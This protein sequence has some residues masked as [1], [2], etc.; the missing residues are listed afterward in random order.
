MTLAG[1][2]AADEV[3]VG[4]STILRA[5][6][7]AITPDR[8]RAFV[9]AVSLAGFDDRAATYWSGRATLC[10]SLDDNDLYDRAF[11]AWFAASPEETRVATPTTAAREPQ[12]SLSTESNSSQS[13]DDAVLAARA[14]TTEVL[15]HRDLARLTEQ[16][17]TKLA[18][19]FDSL[20]VV[21]PLRRAQIGAV[22]L[23]NH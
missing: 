1:N 8:T 21:P 19:L 2:P 3:L 14:S 23:R 6:G 11:T 20:D 12:A 15:R 4:F 13:A 17:R 18:L 7:M 16:E 10:S 22:R 9:E 5:A